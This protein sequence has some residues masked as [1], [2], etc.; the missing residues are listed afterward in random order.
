VKECSTLT[1]S[2]LPLLQ[3]LTSWK[4]SDK[5]RFIRESDGATATNDD[6]EAC[7][8]VT[9]SWKRLLNYSGPGCLIAIAYLDPG[10][11]EADLQVRADNSDYL[12]LTHPPT[13]SMSCRRQPTNHHCYDLSCC[14]CRVRPNVSRMSTGWLLHQVPARMGA[15]RITGGRTHLAGNVSPHWHLHWKA[16]GTTLSVRLGRRCC[17]HSS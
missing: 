8:D 9:F 12:T 11:L 4:M 6:E 10:N 17:N 3:T 5:D 16:L 2:S 7:G 13:A 1:H 15:A 14:S